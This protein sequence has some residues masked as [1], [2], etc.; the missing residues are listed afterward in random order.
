MMPRAP[1]EPEG[2]FAGLRAS[3]IAF[4]A[5]LDVAATLIGS[6]LLLLGIAP[7]AFAADEQRRCTVIAQ[8]DESNAYLAGNL[9]IGSLG[10]VLGAFA[11]AR[12]A[13]R[14]HVRHGGWVAV[15]STAL[16][17]LLT[18]LQP[19][20]ACGP[21]DTVPLWA[22]ATAWLLILPAGVTGGALAAALRR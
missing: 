14:L 5:L 4:G 7:E 1:I 17:V 13:G 2:T 11:G 19:A 12:R 3:A 6:T 21:V 8:L 22:E 10:T 16:G 9:A 15:A 18:A 20:S